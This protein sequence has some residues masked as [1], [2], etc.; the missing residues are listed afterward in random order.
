MVSGWSGCRHLRT[1]PKQPADDPASTVSGSF[2]RRTLPDGPNSARPSRSAGIA[3]KS[4]LAGP[5]PSA[6][7]ASSVWGG[8]SLRT[9]RKLRRG[10]RVSEIDLTEPLSQNGSSHTVELVVP[11]PPEADVAAT[12]SECGSPIRPNR[13]TCSTTCAQERQR[14]RR[15]KRARA[16]GGR[17]R[18][19][20]QPKPKRSGLVDLV[21]QLVGAGLVVRLSVDGVRLEVSGG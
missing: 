12:Y 15:A 5:T 20:A 7:P 9:R 1:S 13:Q 8:T 11:G 18:P 6:T 21:A 4:R 10:E 3:R 16:R 14:L 2:P 17:S 19:P